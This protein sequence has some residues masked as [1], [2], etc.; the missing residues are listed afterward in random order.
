MN[1]KVTAQVGRPITLAERQ[2]AG[3]PVQRSGSEARPF[4][5]VHYLM[6]PAIDA[7][8]ISKSVVSADFYFVIASGSSNSVRGPGTMLPRQARKR[9][10]SSRCLL[11]HP[12][13][14]AS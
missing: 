7:D 3:V 13:R 12:E 9:P 4:Q 5:G 1:R 8:S 6:R 2:P 11:K 14:G 10:P